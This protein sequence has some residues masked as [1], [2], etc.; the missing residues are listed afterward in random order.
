M[1]K[2]EK[3]EGHPIPIVSEARIVP[4]GVVRLNELQEQGW[5][6]IKP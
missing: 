5:S 6:Y 2:M 1:E 4:G 3:Q